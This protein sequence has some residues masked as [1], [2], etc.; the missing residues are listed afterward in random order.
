MLGESIYLFEGCLCFS[1][2]FWWRFFFQEHLFHCLLKHRPPRFVFGFVLVFR[3]SRLSVHLDTVH[4]MLS[5]QHGRWAVCGTSPVLRHTERIPLDPALSKE[6]W[7]TGKNITVIIASTSTECDLAGPVRF[8]P[9]FF[10]QMQQVWFVTSQSYSGF[11]SSAHLNLCSFMFLHS[12][13]ELSS[14]L[15]FFFST[16]P[17]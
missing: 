3:S 12:S 1:T 15:S 8:S 7:L 14:D 10:H 16:I 4:L 9:A 17:C 11:Y 5:I 6:A 13:Y 2:S